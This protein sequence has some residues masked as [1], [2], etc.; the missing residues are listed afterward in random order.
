MR[1]TNGSPKR[2]F[3]GFDGFVDEVVYVVDKRFDS[4][5]YSRIQ[6]IEQ[7]A[8]RISQAAGMS[9]NFEYVTIQTKL[10]GN[11]TIFANALGIMGNVI[12]YAGALGNPINPIFNP[13]I[14][15]CEKCVSLAQNA[16]TDAVEF[17]DGKLI[18]SKLEPFS[19]ITYERLIECYGFDELVTTIKN[20]DLIA[21][22]NWTMITSMNDLMDKFLKNIAPFSTGRQY[23]FFDLADPQ[24][25]KTEDLSEAIRLISSFEGPFKTI[26]SMNLKEAQSI[27]ELYK[28]KFSTLQKLA[29]DLYRNLGITAI[30][31]H[32]LKE[33]CCVYE[34]QYFHAYGPFCE[35][36][37]L[38]TGA[39]D[40]F[41]AG[42]CQGLLQGFAMDQAVRLGTFVSGFY[43]RNGKSPNL[44]ELEEFVNQWNSGLIE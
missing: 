22:M 40:N 39:G 34:N 27:A 13:M 17:Q 21:F 26:L 18:I 11:G 9:T 25:R 32:P 29:Y 41:N 12:S 37:I 20:S 14:E 4:G 16:R 23:A 28:I 36:P 15:Y 3:A 1:R 35:E 30:V 31:I 24:K 10:G 19:Q 6:T 38:T 33:A 42:F 8:Q 44:V 7:Y 2:I 5:N 43:V